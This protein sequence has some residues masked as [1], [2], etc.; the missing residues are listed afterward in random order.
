MITLVI[1]SIQ[2]YRDY[3]HDVSLI[4]GRM[5]QI[6]HVNLRTL[7]NS[8]WVA[9]A[10]ELNIHL[11][12][13]LSLPDMQYLE[14]R[15]GDKVW[16]AVGTDQKDNVITRTFPMTHTYRGSLQKIGNLKV[17]ASL[18]GVYARLIDQAVVI[19]VSNGIKTFLVAGFILFIIVKATC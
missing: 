8:L 14:I 6:Q 5:Q 9:D 2:L 18:N 11:S 15:D 10:S 13:I 3:L 12:G 19:L 7:T 1:S 17:V 4:N 16:A